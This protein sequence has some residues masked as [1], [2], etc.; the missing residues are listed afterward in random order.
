EQAQR[1]KAET[2][3]REVAIPESP[4]ETELDLAADSAA[5]ER[6]R[7]VELRLVDVIVQIAVEASAGLRQSEIGRGTVRVERTDDLAQVRRV[8]LR[9]GVSNLPVQ[10]AVARAGEDVFAFEAGRQQR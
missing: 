6:Q 9:L 5:I 4:A 1:N 8:A 3:R 2:P 7:P 10:Q